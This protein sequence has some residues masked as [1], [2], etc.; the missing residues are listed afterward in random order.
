MNAN[1]W[2]IIAIALVAL[3]IVLAI[4]DRSL[5]SP[6]YLLVLALVVIVG[7]SV[8]FPRSGA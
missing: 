4:M 5:L 6:V 2:Q 3:S 8:R 1:V 7:A